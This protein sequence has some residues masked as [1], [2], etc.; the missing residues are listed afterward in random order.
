MLIRKGQ[1]QS[2]LS[3]TSRRTSRRCARARSV[4]WVLRAG[5]VSSLG[6]RSRRLW[7]LRRG[8]SCRLG[9]VHKGV[10]GDELMV[11]ER[12]CVQCCRNRNVSGRERPLRVVALWRRFLVLVFAWP[13]K[14]ASVVLAWENLRRLAYASFKDVERRSPSNWLSLAV[15]IAR[16]LWG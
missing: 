3:R 6:T 14:G 9:V 7:R 8:G 2:P 15:E 16:D 10:C 11:M 12:W 5:R 1:V 4:G 13:R